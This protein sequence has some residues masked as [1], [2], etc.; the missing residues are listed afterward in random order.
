MGTLGRAA[1]V[2]VVS[3]LLWAALVAGATLRGWGRQ[4]LAPP[5]ASGAFLAAAAQRL[6]AEHAGNAVLLLLERGRVVGE[7]AVS[8]GEPVDHDSVFQV[9][10][11]SKWIS[12]WGVMTLVEDGRLALDVPVGRY[13][14]RWQLPPSD[15]DNEGVT[16]RR[17]LSHTAGLTDGLGYGGFAPGEPV[18]TLEGSL[19]RASDASFGGEGAARLGFDIWGLGTIL[20]ASNG[21]GG[22]VIGH[23]GNNAPPSTPPLASA[24]RPATASWCW[25]AAIR[26]SPAS[27]PASGCTG[28]PAR[29]TS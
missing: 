29:P 16:V 12:A 1:I 14:T 2:A 11:L 7:H 27:W 17:L 8:V 18:Q 6:D 28:R 19:T 22:F 20:Y 3:S 26:C 13:L 25:R 24:P 5:G 15:F 4:A 9:A 10:S 23:D 21:K